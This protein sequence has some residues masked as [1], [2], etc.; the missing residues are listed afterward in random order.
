MKHSRYIPALI[1]LLH[2][3][4]TY[5][6]T[7]KKFKPF[8]PLHN[9]QWGAFYLNAA[10]KFDDSTIVGVGCLSTIGYYSITRKT[11]K[12]ECLPTH[13][14]FFSVG[15][16]NGDLWTGGNKGELWRKRDGNWSN[17]LIPTTDSIMSISISHKHVFV[18]TSRGTLF[19]YSK[20]WGNWNL[21]H[22]ADTM[23]T[24]VRCSGDVVATTGLNG[25]FSLSNDA[26]NTWT[27]VDVH[28]PRSNVRLS[29]VLIAGESS[30][31]LA[32]DYGYI[33]TT[34]DGGTTWT[35]RN[36][37]PAPVHLA[38][39][40]LKRNDSFLNLTQTSNG[41]IYA[42]GSFWRYTM[43]KENYQCVYRS[44]DGGN[45]WS[46]AKLERTHPL[47]VPSDDDWPL[48]LLNVIENAI[49]TIMFNDSVGYCVASGNSAY[50][51]STVINK[52]VNGGDKW[53][54]ED[55]QSAISEWVF[56]ESDQVYNLYDRRWIL[57]AKAAREPGSVLVLEDYEWQNGRRTYRPEKRILKISYSL[58]TPTS[59]KVDT[60]ATLPYRFSGLARYDDY[61][62]LS[63]F[64]SDTI[65]YGI[66]DTNFNNIKLVTNTLPGLD[67]TA[68]LF[69]ILLSR[70]DGTLFGLIETKDSDDSTMG[71]T[72]II[73]SKDKGA[74][75]QRM[76]LEN[77][78]PDV[79][80]HHASWMTLYDDTVLVSMNN[81]YS[82][83]NAYSDYAV[84]TDDMKLR[85]IDSLPM[86]L[87]GYVWNLNTSGSVFSYN[88]SIFYL[89]YFNT[90]DDSKKGNL[91]AIPFDPK[92]GFSLDYRIVKLL[93]GDSLRS[94][95]KRG[96][97]VTI[98]KGDTLV[99]LSEYSDPY[100]CPTFDTCYPI[101]KPRY[102]LGYAPLSTLAKDENRLVFASGYRTFWAT[103]IQ[104]VV[105]SIADG[106][107]NVGAPVPGAK[108][109]C[110]QPGYSLLLY[111][112]EGRLMQYTRG[113]GNAE[114]AFME[115]TTSASG[116]VFYEFYTECGIFR[117]VLG[118]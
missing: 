114:D 113:V 84:V 27:Q 25:W 40:P 42:C 17:M 67:F 7:A 26:G 92:K 35:W 73:Y 38:P 21:V 62:I 50:G 107:N 90:A 52:S 20:E 23:L 109:Q 76:P 12:W 95:P 28:L 71:R 19:R 68:T 39:K 57:S 72:G 37:V 6:I 18:A 65:Y 106:D 104:E 103:T 94:F 87:P 47:D 2:S 8:V 112:L 31:V 48:N 54:F 59:L 13:D 22:Q 3:V 41:H 14:D 100:I 24:R 101:Q 49:G 91:L 102:G 56:D 1:I 108:P 81:W 46:R 93:D 15:I 44:T 51:L 77:P 10:D 33:A 32:G 86:V 83:T 43:A 88:N 99:L 110:T 116:V 11:W 9:C 36:I 53:D 58:A 75:W 34:E 29:D 66:C 78:R 118:K 4:I 16:D 55:Y 69:R 80:V 5:P 105:T 30:F 98:T 85:I 117:G 64:V 63:N 111:N 70:S 89:N 79:P 96:Y 82:G 115:L 97:N 45:T 61:Y 74:S 60:V